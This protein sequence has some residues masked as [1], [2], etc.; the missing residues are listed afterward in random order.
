MPLSYFGAFGG[1]VGGGTA[2][3]APR[4]R[5]RLGSFIDFNPSGH[6]VALGLNKRVIEVRTRNA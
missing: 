6:N 2:L 1:A 5:V 4:L 3:R